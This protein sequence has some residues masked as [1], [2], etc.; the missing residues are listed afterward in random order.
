MTEIATRASK[1]A[2]NTRPESAG[3][4][5]KT[6]RG[7]VLRTLRVPEFGQAS[8]AKIRIVNDGSETEYK[9]FL[10]ALP[11]ESGVRSP[12]SN[13][14]WSPSSALNSEYWYLP[15][16][17][18]GKTIDTPTFEVAESDPAEVDLIAWNVNDPDSAGSGIRLALIVLDKNDVRFEIEPIKGFD[19]EL[20]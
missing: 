11:N 8:S 7:K 5:F 17:D 6:K 15:A 1:I 13:S 3:G 19:G 2:N 18:T 4:G 16:L 12:S 14:G 20:S 9:D 10:I